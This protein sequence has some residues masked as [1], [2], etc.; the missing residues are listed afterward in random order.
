MSE[1]LARTASGVSPLTVACV[2]TGKNA[3]VATRPCGVAISRRRAAPSVAS[4]RN[5]KASGMLARVAWQYV[6]IECSALCCTLPTL[7]SEQQTGIAV[8]IEPVP[9]PDR[10]RIGA[11]HHLE[12]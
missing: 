11:L 2:P 7:R 1:P 5:E 10:V 9:L 6:E 12:P 3:G 4:K 8:R